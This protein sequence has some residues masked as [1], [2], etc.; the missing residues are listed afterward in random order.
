MSQAQLPSAS[1][2]TISQERSSKLDRSSQKPKPK[3]QQIQMI[4]I[5]KQVVSGQK[6]IRKI[7][8]YQNKKHVE[9]RKQVANFKIIDLMQQM[10]P[11]GPEIKVQNIDRKKVPE[12]VVNKDGV[13]EL[14]MLTPESRA[15]H[16]KQEALGGTA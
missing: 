11:Q 10:P 15:K 2:S 7:T 12:K 9:K 14:L 1:H 4:N 6:N 8:N 3:K 16:G 5:Q 13:H